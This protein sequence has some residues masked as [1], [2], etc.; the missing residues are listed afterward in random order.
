MV[1]EKILVLNSGGFDSVTMLHELRKTKPSA[2]IHTLFFDYG[3]RSEVMEERCATKV[4]NKL[5]CKFH[6]IKLPSM[7]WTN[8]NF[9]NDDYKSI[10]SQYLEYRNLIFLSYALSLSQSIGA[11]EIYLAVLKSHWGYADT[12]PEFLTLMNSLSMLQ[13]IKIIAPY[14]DLDKPD[15]MLRAYKYGVTPNTWWSCD[16]PKSEEFL[17]SPCGECPDCKSLEEA[18]EYLKVTPYRAHF[19]KEFSFEEAVKDYPLKE[20][21]V[22]LNNKCQ[23]NCKH[24]FYGFDDMVEAPLTTDEMRS[25]ITQALL[26]GVKSIHYA[27]K[28]PLYDGTIFEYVEWVHDSYPDVEQSVVTNGINVPKYA[29][30]ISRLGLKVF[31]SVDFNHFLRS[32]TTA[33]DALDALQSHGIKPIVFIDLHQNNY[34]KIYG[35]MEKLYFKYRIDTFHLRTLRNVGNATYNTLPELSVK[36][37]IEAIE[38]A[39]KFNVAHYGDINMVSVDIGCAYAKAFLNE[40]QFDNCS[41]MVNWELENIEAGTN[42]INDKFRLNIEYFCC[43]YISSVTVTPDGFILGC[44]AEVANPNYDKVSVGNVRD[45][46]LYALVNK[47]KTKCSRVNEKWNGGTPDVCQFKE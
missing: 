8:S 20:L 42:Y 28:E 11:A 32:E 33:L 2:Q 35:L 27:G 43:K 36:Q 37:V 24:C 15:V 25:V 47:G 1:Q 23:L 7:D 45:Y 17:I 40:A 10:E 22:L 12:S 19:Q 38:Q 41:D 6:K 9:F 34:D 14:R 16:T 30:G 13:G 39:Y 18:N 26:L 44:G 5:D 31:L 46:S 21:R 3:Q 29:D 4:S